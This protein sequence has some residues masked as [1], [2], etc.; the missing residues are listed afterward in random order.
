MPVAEHN[1]RNPFGRR[2]HR[3]A[4]QQQRA[5]EPVEKQS[6]LLFKRAMIWPVGSF[7]PFVELCL[8]D[9]T[10]PEETVL[11]RAGRDNTKSAAS[12]GSGSPPVRPFYHR[13]IDLILAA[14]AIYGRP[15][16]PG[17]DCADTALHRA[18]DQP[19]DQRILQ[20]DQG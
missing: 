4:I 18:P 13:R 15:R 6:N 10:P 2:R 12:T 1:R 20:R 17:D 11:L 8:A 9:R 7:Q 19:V 3:M 14:V 5:A 16:R